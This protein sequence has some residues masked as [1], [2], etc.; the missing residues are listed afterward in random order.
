VFSNN[1]VSISTRETKK[2]V[3]SLNN[4]GEKESALAAEIGTP[5]TSKIRSDKQYLKQYD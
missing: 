5:S 2:D 4:S 3:A 1:V